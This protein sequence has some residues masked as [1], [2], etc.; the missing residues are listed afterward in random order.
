MALGNIR[1][2]ATEVII[3]TGVILGV[4]DW[5]TDIVYAAIKDFDSVGT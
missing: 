2:T 4:L 5:A 1:I 3:W